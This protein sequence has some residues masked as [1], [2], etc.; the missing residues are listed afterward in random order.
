M[1]SDGNNFL[2]RRIN[3]GTSVVSTLAGHWERD[4]HQDGVGSNAGFNYPWGIALN[5]V[6]TVAV[7]V[8]TVNFR[9]PIRICLVLFICNCNGGILLFSIVSHKHRSMVVFKLSR[10]VL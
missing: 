4:A 1:Q 3:L 6:G 7:V 9:V 5:A 8:S 2:V 10:V